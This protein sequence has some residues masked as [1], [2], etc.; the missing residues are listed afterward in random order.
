MTKRA[1]VVVLTGLFAFMVAG[2]AGAVPATGPEIDD[3]V[4]VF[5]G[6]LTGTTPG[7]CVKPAEDGQSITTNTSTLIGGMLGSSSGN[8]F[9][10]SGNLKMILT[11][12]TNTDTGEGL[13]QG[14]FRLTYS[15]DPNHRLSGKA[16]LPFTIDA[17]TLTTSWRGMVT[18]NY[19]RRAPTGWLNN[20]DQL[21]ANVQMQ[22]NNHGQFDGGFGASDSSLLSFGPNDDVS[23]TTTNKC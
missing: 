21:V 7:P 3:A 23:I 8:D 12:I 15:G 9:S 13:S 18:A 14:V 2:V 20:G 1:V 6:V 11:N 22:A 4:A 10:L 19:Q 16:V 17:N 5:S